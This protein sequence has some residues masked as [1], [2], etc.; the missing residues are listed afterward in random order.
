MAGGGLARPPRP[1]ELEDQSDGD[2]VVIGAVQSGRLEAVEVVCGGQARFRETAS[3]RRG[4]DNIALV[5]T[6]VRP[7][8]RLDQC[9]VVSATPPGRG[10]AEAGLAAANDLYR[11]QPATLDGAYDDSV[12]VTLVLEFGRP[13][14]AG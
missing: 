13:G 8:T 4:A 9:D 10:F 11:F 12:T 6:G 7:D 14:R 3:R 1:A 5:Q 2:R